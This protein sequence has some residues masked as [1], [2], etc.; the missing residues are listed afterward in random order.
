MLGVRTAATKNAPTVSKGHPK[1]APSLLPRPLRPDKRVFLPPELW[2]GLSRAA[3]FHEE[4]FAKMDRHESVSRNDIIE[5]F[6]TWA[7]DTYWKD[8]GGEPLP[9][10]PDREKKVAAFAAKMAKEEADERKARLPDAD[11]SD[12]K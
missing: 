7:L 2:E 12:S 4:A 8:K 11:Q 1:S 6:L 9:S 5:S 3:K 10:G